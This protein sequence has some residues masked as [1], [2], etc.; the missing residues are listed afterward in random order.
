M[1]ER[2]KQFTY[3]DA[4]S[5]V[6]FSTDWKDGLPASIL[7]WRQLVGGDN[8]SYDHT[9]K[10]GFCFVKQNREGK[11]LSG[12]WECPADEIC[13]FAYTGE[14]SKQEVLDMLLGLDLE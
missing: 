9:E 4:D 1:T 10:C 14:V 6:G 12:C 8:I 5:M 3:K 7:K 2:E 11:G 13:K